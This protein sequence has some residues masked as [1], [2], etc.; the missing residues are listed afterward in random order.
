MIIVGVSKKSPSSSSFMCGSSNF[1]Y[2]DIL[3]QHRLFPNEK[4]HP[5]VNVTID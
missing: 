3:L 2:I 5:I 1:A 4:K